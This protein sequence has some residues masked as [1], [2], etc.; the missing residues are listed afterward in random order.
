MDYYTKYFKYKQKYL[1]L[2]GGIRCSDEFDDFD[3]NIDQITH[4][5]VNTYKRRFDENGNKLFYNLINDDNDNDDDEEDEGKGYDNTFINI[6]NVKIENC[7]VKFSFSQKVNNVNIN[8]PNMIIKDIIDNTTKNETSITEYIQ[9][10]LKSNVILKSII[11]KKDNLLKSIKLNA[12]KYNIHDFMYYLFIHSLFGEIIRKDIILRI[13]LSEESHKILK[14]EL[15]KNKLLR[16]VEVSD[17][18]K[19]CNSRDIINEITENWNN[20][21]KRKF[22]F[23]Q[24]QNNYQLFYSDRDSDSNINNYTYIDIF[25]VNVNVNNCTVDINFYQKIYDVLITIPENFILKIMNKLQKPLHLNINSDIYMLITNIIYKNSKNRSDIINSIKPIIPDSFKSIKINLL[26]NNIE[27]YMY[28]FL[29]HS[30]I[31]EILRIDMDSMIPL[32][33]KK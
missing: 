28:Y 11:P 32:I 24:V 14:K 8:I 7:F 18:I 20:K 27:Y 21:F 15:G 3:I 1:D 16:E 25:N 2:K 17:K 19:F 29:I 23:N 5:W 13:I 33:D 30:I 4:Y 12:K 9:Q 31:G 10:I 26:N 6:S 22:I